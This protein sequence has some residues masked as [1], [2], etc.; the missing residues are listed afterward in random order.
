MPDQ[1]T[2]EKPMA[3]T[4]EMIHSLIPGVSR[5]LIRSWIAS[6]QLPAVRIGE[7]RRRLLVLREDLERVLRER[8]MGGK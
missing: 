3:L 6:G 5:S 2:T 7:G 4:V 8:R 1:G